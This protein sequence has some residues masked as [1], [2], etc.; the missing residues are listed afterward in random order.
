MLV[1]N[2]DHAGPKVMYRVVNVPVSVPGPIRDGA[3][4]GVDWF[5]CPNAGQASTTFALTQGLFFLYCDKF[6]PF[7]HLKSRLFT[8]GL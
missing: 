2:G 1:R 8:T 5:P 7:S 4:T 3:E 6:T